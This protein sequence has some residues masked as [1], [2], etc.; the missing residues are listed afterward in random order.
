MIYLDEHGEFPGRIKALAES[1][2]ET[3]WSGGAARVKYLEAGEDARR[4]VE[5]WRSAKCEAQ[6]EALE[7]AREL[8]GVASYG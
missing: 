5:G 7:R 4:Y 6:R 1:P 2:D 3:L 8:S